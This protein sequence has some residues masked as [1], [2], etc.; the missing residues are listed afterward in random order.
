[1]ECQIKNSNL[2]WEERHYIFDKITAIMGVGD[3]SRENM[4]SIGSVSISRRDRK[5][6]FSYKEE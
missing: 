6:L 3:W 1:M 2:G 5:G 4:P